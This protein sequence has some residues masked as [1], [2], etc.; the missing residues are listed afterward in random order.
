MT[1]NFIV[2]KSTLLKLTLLLLCIP[3]TLGF[4]NIF[5]NTDN[6]SLILDKEK[7][8]VGK[9][10]G[11]NKNLD[12]FSSHITKEL[13]IKNEIFGDINTKMN[14]NKDTNPTS[15][16]QTEVDNDGYKE[17]ARATAQNYEREFIKHMLY[18]TMNIASESED[19]SFAENLWQ[20]KY[21]EALVDKINVKGDG[22]IAQRLYQDIMAKRYSKSSQIQSNQIQSK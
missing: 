8:L 20:A 6:L 4:N 7:Y 12:S 13:S 22:P 3:L 5:K 11:S 17:L 19:K 18:Q 2:N 1:T 15:K 21:T 9:T 16:T 10:G 14:Y